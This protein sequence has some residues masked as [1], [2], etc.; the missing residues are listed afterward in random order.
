MGACAPV[1]KFPSDIGKRVALQPTLEFG[2]LQMEPEVYRGGGTLLAGSITAVEPISSG[3]LL[4]TQQLP[5]LQQVAY[6]SY[7]PME[8]TPTEQFVLFYPGHIDPQG[9]ILGNKFIALA[10]RREL[11]GVTIK[12]VSKTNPYYVATCLHIWKTG[13]NEISDFRDRYNQT[14]ARLEEDTYCTKAVVPTP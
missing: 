4:V 10:D 5:V 9:L 2:V 12:G 11:V 6:P 14:Y 7:R 13:H 1:E 3:L 8:A